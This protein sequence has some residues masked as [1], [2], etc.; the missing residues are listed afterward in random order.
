MHLCRTAQSFEAHPSIPR[1]GDLAKP[2]QSRKLCR[3]PG[4]ATGQRH[5]QTAPAMPKTATAIP[6]GMTTVLLFRLLFATAS[7]LR[8]F[9]R[10]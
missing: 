5:A 2:E 10:T 6:I 3:S 9:W 1:S 4:T 7:L 8:K